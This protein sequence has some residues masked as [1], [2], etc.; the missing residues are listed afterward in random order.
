MDCLSKYYEVTKE[1]FYRTTFEI[2]KRNCLFHPVLGEFPLNYQNPQ[3]V[4]LLKIKELLNDD[5]YDNFCKE[6]YP[7]YLNYLIK[8]H[9]FIRIKDKRIIYNWI[10]DSYSKFLEENNIQFFEH[11][12]IPLN[13][14]EKEKQELREYK[15]EGLKT[16]A[17]FYLP[18]RKQYFHCGSPMTTGDGYRTF[19]KECREYGLNPFNL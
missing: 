5:K 16:A 10:S 11:V 15:I 8:F 18:M 9:N 19:M 12:I 14:T 13:L 2:N 3:K 1:D 4:V 7:N 6:H 17:K